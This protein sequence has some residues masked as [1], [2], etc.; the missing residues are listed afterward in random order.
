MNDRF[1]ITI[2]R[3]LG[4][5]GRSI[6]AILSRRLGVEL[7]DKE[8]LMMAARRSGLCPECFESVDERRSHS[9]L[10]TLIGYL[11]TPFAGYA[12][13]GENV[14]ATEQLFKIQSDTIRE[15]A[16]AGSCVFVGR[17]ADYVLRDDPRKVSVFITADDGDRVRRICAR[18][19]C[20]EEEARR[21][22]ERGDESRAAYYN[23]VSAGEWGAAAGYDLCLNSSRL[24]DEGSAEIIMDFTARK[25]GIKLL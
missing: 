6:A 19:G 10:S 8:L 16:T 15:I 18:T 3:Q 1:V 23:Y 14:L 9:M 12:E 2:G 5:G 22:M 11:R 17:C 24:G 7:Y 4:S 21:R 20:T 25:L 13:H